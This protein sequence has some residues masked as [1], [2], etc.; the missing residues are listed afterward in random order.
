MTEDQLRQLP[1]EYVTIGSHTMTHPVLPAIDERRLA[2]ELA[3]SRAKLEKMLNREV[4]LFSF[5][6]G[7]FNE[8]VVERC[9]EARYERVFTALPILAFTKPQEFVTGRVG[10]TPGDWPI[11]FHLKLAG[12]YRWLPYAFALKRRLFS[13]VRGGEAAPFGL[14]RQQT[15]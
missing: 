9:R 13:I 3:G 15:S 14:K 7:A 1:S 11:E 8:R 4:K 10:A 5:P 12:A 2:E 6:Y